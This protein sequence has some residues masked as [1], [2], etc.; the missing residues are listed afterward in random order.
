MI[1][2][3]RGA[4]TVSSNT[5]DEIVQRTKELLNDLITENAIEA[6]QVASVFISMTED[7]DDTFPAKAL[8]E[9]DGW[10]Y[11][12]VMCMRELAV[13]N[14]LAK[15]IRIMIHL[16]TDQQQEAMYHAYHYEAVQLR[17]DLIRGEEEE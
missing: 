15:C 9:I 8:R 1:R 17:P 7:L 16:N 3:V 4:T 13:P 11:V 5:G 2:G 6:N 10:T 14:S 12:P